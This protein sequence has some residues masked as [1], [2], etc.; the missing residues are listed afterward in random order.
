MKLRVVGALTVAAVCLWSGTALASGTRTHAQI[1]TPFTASGKPAFRVADT[2]SGYCLGGSVGVEH[3]GAWHCLSGGQ[4]FDPC[5]GSQKAKGIVLCV[6]QGP[7]DR[8]IVKM[9]LT[10]P[11]PLQSGHRGRATLSGLPW[12]ILT[13]S[14]WKCVIA[15][16]ETNQVD[17][18]R[19]NYLCTG[20]DKWLWGAPQRSHEPW[21]I[22]AAPDTA[23]TL[24]DRA[25]IKAA[26]F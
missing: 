7:W 2:V 25:R 4:V 20:T 26:W 17:G 19:Q 10:Q 16:S 24:K 5:F 11:L 22:W 8:P 13:T 9:K 3:A 12:A 23:T 1:Y 18:Q 15:R 21:R 6:T 14:G